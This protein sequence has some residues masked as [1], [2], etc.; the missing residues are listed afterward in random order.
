MEALVQPR[1]WSDFPPPRAELFRTLR[2]AA[3]E[4]LVIEDNFFV[5]T[6]LP[7]SVLRPLSEAEMA[8]YRAPFIEPASR[9]PTLTWARDLPI[10]GEP[11]DIAELVDAYGGWA[12]TSEVPKLFISAEP[13][14][15]LTGRARDFC[16]GWRNQREVSVPGIHY[17]QEDSPVEIGTALREFISALEP[18]R[19]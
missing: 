9:L 8:A 10:D 7:K 2:G 12:A 5:E 14:A 1:L 15:L 6:V 3:G 16:R 13:G 4:R 19:F 17:L 11:G 18:D